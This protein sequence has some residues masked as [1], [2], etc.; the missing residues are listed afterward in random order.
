MISMG[1]LSFDLFQ[2]HF[3]TSEYQSGEIEGRWGVSATTEGRPEWPIF[4]FWVASATG[5]VYNFKFDFT[6]YPNSAPTAVLWDLENKIVLPLEKRP[7]KTKR[8]NQVFKIW[9]PECN[10]LPC[11][12]LAIVGHNTWPQE[13]PELIWDNGKDTFIKYLLEL[14]YILN[15]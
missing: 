3:E 10:Y 1:S 11:D 12:R 8:Q 14:Y 15:S 6:D 2:C 13:H 5:V 4:F 9:G 7:L